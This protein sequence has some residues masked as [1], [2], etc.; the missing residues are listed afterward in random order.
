MILTRW[1]ARRAARVLIDHLHGEVVAAA[2]RP[3][4]Y[5]DCGVPDDLDGRFEMM[6]LH[7]D[8][9]LR[10]LNEAGAADLAQELVDR[11]FEGFDDALR[12]MSISDIGVAKRMTKFAGAYFGRAGVYGPA[13]EAGDETALA[14]AL[15]RNALRA[16]DVLAPEACK[17]A[18]RALAT[19]TLLAATPR[20][21]FET[22]AFIYPVPETAP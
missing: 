3:A 21:A 20:A 19:Q 13:L 7:A 1:R 22:V 8:L 6:V 5:T 16:G 4:L 11:L 18:A 17:L 9:L 15:A 10:R 12:E 2:R 14:A